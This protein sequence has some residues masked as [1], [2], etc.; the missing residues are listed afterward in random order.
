[1]KKRAEK[2]RK[3]NFRIAIIAFHAAVVLLIVHHFIFRPMFLDWGAPESIQRQIF[4]GD[5]LTDGTHHT[6]AVLIDATPEELWP[7]LHQIGQDR[8]GFYSYQWLENLFA[9]EMSNVYEIKPEFQ[10]PRQPGDTIWLATKDHYNGQG[11]QILAEVSAFKS[12]VMVGGDDYSK[13]RNGRKASGSW[14]FYLFPES[15]DKTWLVARSS[16]GDLSAPERLIRYFTFEVPHYIM[17]KKMLK[18]IKKLAESRPLKMN[19]PRT[20]K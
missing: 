3:R 2:K 15:P 6:R 12:M 9:A 19:E 13:I 5:S 1:M 11:Y 18:S 17:E 10:W 8:G 16:D 7:W 4:P 20:M 14:A